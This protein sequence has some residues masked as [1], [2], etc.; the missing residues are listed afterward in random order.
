MILKHAGKITDEFD[1]PCIFKFGILRQGI[2]IN[3][4]INHERLFPVGD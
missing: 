3:G 1:K 4:I 2:Y